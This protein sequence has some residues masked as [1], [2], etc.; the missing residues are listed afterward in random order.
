MFLF[1]P[2]WIAHHF[3]CS[4]SKNKTKK[5]HK[6]T[7]HKKIPP[8]LNPPCPPDPNLT[9]FKSLWYPTVE[10]HVCHD[11]RCIKS[12]LSR[13]FQGL[14]CTVSP[15]ISP[16]FCHGRTLFSVFTFGSLGCLMV[17]SF[18]QP[19]SAENKKKC[20]IM[21]E[22]A[23]FFAHVGCPIILHRSSFLNM[24]FFS[25]ELKAEVLLWANPFWTRVTQS[26]FCGS[27]DDCE[28][29]GIHGLLTTNQRNCSSFNFDCCGSNCHL[30]H[31]S[32]GRLCS[33]YFSPYCV[34]VM[35]RCVLMRLLRLQD[36]KCMFA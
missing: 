13:E 11:K 27:R 2:I 25:I 32:L 21:S 34:W 12:G 33:K 14:G 1:K 20:N 30:R 28:T 35:A 3:K 19:P 16:L 18:F 4:T 7:P 29:Q 31:L 17:T 10:W 6:K 5:I 22:V 8:N 36:N 24:Y 15:G 23:E 9:C 26:G